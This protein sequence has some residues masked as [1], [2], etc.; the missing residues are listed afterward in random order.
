M[1]EGKVPN[2][3]LKPMFFYHLKCTNVYVTI[4]YMIEIKLKTYMF[5]IKKQ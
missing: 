2:F 1:Y 4:K 5:K 3:E